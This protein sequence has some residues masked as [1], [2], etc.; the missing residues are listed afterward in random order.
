MKRARVLLATSVIPLALSGLAIPTNTASATPGGTGAEKKSE[1]QLR[2]KVRRPGQQPGQVTVTGPDG[3][4]VTLSRTTVLRDLTPGRYEISARTV[5][6]KRWTSTPTVTRE[7]VRVGAKNPK[8][9]TKVSYGVIVSKDVE[10]VAPSAIG[11]FTPPRPGSLGT[12]ISSERVPVGGIIASATGKAAPAGMLVRVV[13]SKNLAGDR[14]LYEVK[15]STLQEALPSGSFT[16]SFDTPLSRPGADAGARAKNKKLPISCKGQVDAGVS[17]D[18]DGG[19]DAKIKGKWDFLDSSI[20]LTARPHATAEVRAWLA[21]AGEC[22]LKELRLWRHAFAPINIQIGPVPLVIVPN[23]ELLA[24]AGVKATG[25]VEVKAG[26]GVEANVGASANRKGL[27]TWGN[28][29]RFT[30]NASFEVGATASAE[31]YGKAKLVG[32]LY[33]LAGPYA[34]VTVGVEAK[35][36]TKGNPWWTVD[37][38]AKAGVGVQVNKCVKVIFKKVCVEFDRAKDDLLEKRIPIINAGGP[39]AGPPPVKDI[40]ADV[41]GAGV[42]VTNGSTDSGGGTGRSGALVTSGQAWTLS[43]GS[44]GD[45]AG[46][47]ADRADTDRGKPGHPELTAFAGQETYD[48]TFLSMDVKPTGNRLRV[49]YVFSTDEFPDYVGSKND[50]MAVFV[51]GKNCALVPGTTTPV[52]VNS[53]NDKTNSQYFVDNRGGQRPTRM[54]GLTV[55]LSCITPVTPG[56]T[57]K[58]LIGVADAGDAVYDSAVA[59]LDKGITSFHQ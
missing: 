54:N 55:P 13:T 4:A 44:I 43:T 50:V 56:K 5:S 51:D 47:A 41:A 45:V 22:S 3:F 17:L 26:V 53:V 2:V 46:A 25:S 1:P 10:A 6:T 14:Y 28:G 24:G 29:P 36:D 21:A 40:L 30:K 19:L 57:V 39:L 18:L 35:V 33:G 16:A 20:E 11:K 32:E 38:F 8:R 48:A 49:D 27:K 58:V 7:V 52:S 42:T 15:Q 34:V 23:L 37:A 59:V 31:V 9:R 12:V